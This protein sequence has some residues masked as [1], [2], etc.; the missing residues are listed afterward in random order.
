[1]IIRKF[2]DFEYLTNPISHRWSTDSE[3]YFSHLFFEIF[4][5]VKVEKKTKISNKLN[6]IRRLP[7]KNA[8]SVKGKNMLPHLLTKFSPHRGICTYSGHAGFS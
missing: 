7:F 1:M 8:H 6:P 3:I 4:N 2:V 5:L